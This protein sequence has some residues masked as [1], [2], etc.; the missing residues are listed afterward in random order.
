MASGR[1]RECARMRLRYIGDNTDTWNPE[2]TMPINNGLQL[3]NRTIAVVFAYIPGPTIAGLFSCYSG[4]LSGLDGQ[5]YTLNSLN[6]GSKNGVLL[7]NGGHFL[8][9]R[10]SAGMNQLYRRRVV[11]YQLS[12]EGANAK[13][14]FRA[15]AMPTALEYNHGTITVSDPDLNETLNLMRAGCARYYEFRITAGKLT[16]SE[17]D[18]LYDRLMDKWQAHPFGDDQTGQ[19]VWE[20][21]YSLNYLQSNYPSPDVVQQSWIGLGLGGRY[22]KKWW[23]NDHRSY[24]DLEVSQGQLDLVLDNNSK[25]PYIQ[26]GGHFWSRASVAD[27]VGFPF[28]DDARSLI[29]SLNNSSSGYLLCKGNGT[30]VMQ[31][32][33]WWIY[34]STTTPA[35][36]TLRLCFADGTQQEFASTGFGGWSNWPIAMQVAPFGTDIRVMMYGGAMTT[37]L[38]QTVLGKTLTSNANPVRLRGRFSTDPQIG[39]LLY[40]EIRLSAS[41][42]TAIEMQKLTDWVRTKWS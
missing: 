37:P 15:G 38:I 40:R 8:S 26:V 23:C 2:M 30:A 35:V 24:F 16:A 36:Y 14:L 31:P 39:G 42:L 21:Q 11:L 9:N 20:S 13:S 22:I 4:T 1:I 17:F 7:V 25:C 32:G 34:L 12:Q 10:H 6:V 18:A 3:I 29:I 27:S 19:L 5:Q 33:D 41:T 28:I